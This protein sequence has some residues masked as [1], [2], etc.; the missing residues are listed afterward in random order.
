LDLR[1]F[2]STALRPLLEEETHVWSQSLAW[3]YRSSAEMILRYV[4]ARVL[5]GYVAVRNGH[6]DGYCFFVYEGSKGVIGDLYVHREL[7]DAS[8]TE[9]RLLAH[10]I[11]TLQ[12]SPGLHRVEAQLLLHP[13]GAVAAPFLQEGFHQHR[14]LFMLLPLASGAPNGADGSPIL[15]SDIE[16][17]HWAES[18]YHAAAA[19]IT[20]SYHGHI[21]AD[22]NDQYHS[23]SGSLRFLNNIV[24]FPGCGIFDQNAS[25]IAIHRPSRTMAGLIL[26]S[27]VKD[28]VG[29]V[30]QVCI[31]PEHRGRR[32]GETLLCMT[33]AE[34]HRRKFSSLSLTVTEA[35]RGA[36]GLYLRLGYRIQRVFDAFVWER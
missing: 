13:S 30:T 23:T 8:A 7:K 5:P 33:S 17:R 6:A 31:I 4:D 36:V 19:V 11:S 15:P 21:D 25:F 16:V 1:H 3:D 27:R 12:Q 14:R 9:A 20:A 22:I 18:D 2:S 29:H 34:L 26:C 28:D 10:G 24:R 32:L 35:N